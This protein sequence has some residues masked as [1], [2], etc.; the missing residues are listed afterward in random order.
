MA[1][2]TDDPDLPL[3]EVVSE[4]TVAEQ[5]YAAVASLATAN[6]VVPVPSAEIEMV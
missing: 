6:E 4:R 5:P 1:S 2:V 3:A